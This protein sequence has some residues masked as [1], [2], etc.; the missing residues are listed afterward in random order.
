MRLMIIKLIEFWSDFS[1]K[2]D[3]RKL[4]KIWNERIWIFDCLKISLQ[5]FSFMINFCWTE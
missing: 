2:F 1:M 3:I 4:D 5:I